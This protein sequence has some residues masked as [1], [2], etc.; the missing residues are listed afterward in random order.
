M[1]YLK[2][3]YNWVKVDFLWGDSARATRLIKSGDIE[4]IKWCLEN[5][6]DPNMRCQFQTP[7]GETITSNTLRYAIAKLCKHDLIEL[8]LKHGANPNEIDIGDPQN[9]YQFS[10]LLR[11]ALLGD[12]AL[13]KLLIQYHANPNITNESG[14]TPLRVAAAYKN[15]EVCKLLIEFGADHNQLNPELLN[16][17]KNGQYSESEFLLECG[18]N[19]NGC[20][21]SFEETPLL[22][23]AFRGHAAL[24][25]LLIDY[26]AD[27]NKANCTKRTPLYQARNIQIYDLLLSSGANTDQN[28]QSA[29][30]RFLLRATTQNDYDECKLLIERGAPL[31][32]TYRARLEDIFE[33]QVNQDNA[34][35]R[36]KILTRLSCPPLSKKH[37]VTMPG[38]LDAFGAALN[39]NYANILELLI[40][41]GAH[42]SINQFGHT[43]LMRILL[44]WP[45]MLQKVCYAPNPETFHTSFENVWHLLWCLQQLEL[46]YTL[47]KDLKKMLVTYCAPKDLG[48]C[49]IARAMAGKRIDQQFQKTTSDVLYSA[50]IEQL[51]SELT[52][53]HKNMRML[54]TDFNPAIHFYEVDA[55]NIEEKYGKEIR[56]NI[57]ERI[58]RPILRC[59]NVIP[60]DE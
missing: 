33:E 51:K 29:L 32:H 38:A 13:C 16:A 36:H 3:A 55:E 9:K 35:E 40:D 39:V 60:E 11:A 28:Y 48:S 37:D 41:Q 21:K 18:A 17:V 58:A 56:A 22:K 26:G 43:R 45:K 4:Q 7:A 53:T 1:H 5:G 57:E 31:H 50:T 42:C 54:A 12:A 20:N 2:S 14:W 8:L 59:N 49:M 44:Y 24:C 25:K 23:A 30:A 10:P 27:P 6:A 15:H 19:P 46:S 34:I 52:Y 47:P